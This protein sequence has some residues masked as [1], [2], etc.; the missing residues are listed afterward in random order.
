MFPVLLQNLASRVMVSWEGKYIL[1]RK[2]DNIGKTLI[3]QL[4]FHYISNFEDQTMMFLSMKIWVQTTFGTF[5][6]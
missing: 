5:I 3:P 4:I 1:P 6:Q 2:C